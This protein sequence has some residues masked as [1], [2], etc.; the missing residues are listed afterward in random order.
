MT[1]IKLLA[2]V[3]LTTAKNQNRD[4]AFARGAAS[5]RRKRAP[6]MQMART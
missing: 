1:P 4:R 3:A 2:I 6:G 5:A